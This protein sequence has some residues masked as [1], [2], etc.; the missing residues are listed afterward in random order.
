MLLL[1]LLST[2]V[3]IVLQFIGA[4]LLLLCLYH[5][6]YCL[7]RHGIRLCA[8]HRIKVEEASTHKIRVQIP[9]LAVF[10]WLVALTI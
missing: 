8:H 3:V 6:K 7:G 9:M 10:M 2:Y 1:M 5:A 4:C